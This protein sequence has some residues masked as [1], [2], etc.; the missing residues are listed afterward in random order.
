M[1]QQVITED[2]AIGLRGRRA[3]GRVV[4]TGAPRLPA[5]A[6]ALGGRGPAPGPTAGPSAPPGRA[7]RGTAMVSAARA[8]NFALQF[9]GVGP[10]NAVRCGEL[11]L[12]LAAM[13][14][15]QVGLAQQRTD[16][17]AFRLQ[18]RGAA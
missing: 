8:G 3:N 6:E 9:G 14:G 5:E 16:R 11:G 7:E 4:A 15:A 12:G 18:T 13:A 1:E 2:R 17:G 10:P